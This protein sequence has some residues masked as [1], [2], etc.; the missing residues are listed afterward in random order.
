VVFAAQIFRVG[1]LTYGQRLDLRS[2][3]AALGGRGS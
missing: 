2:I 1:M 3:R